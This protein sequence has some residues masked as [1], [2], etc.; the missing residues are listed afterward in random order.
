[1]SMFSEFDD[2]FDLLVYSDTLRLCNIDRSEPKP[3]V[4]HLLP[5]ISKLCCYIIDPPKDN[6]CLLRRKCFALHR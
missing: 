1:M 3:Y 2:A 4:L 5:A 6:S